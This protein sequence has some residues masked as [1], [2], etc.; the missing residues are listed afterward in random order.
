MTDRT[1]PLTDLHEVRAL[2]AAE[3]DNV[4]FAYDRTA[5][6]SMF[7]R[8]LIGS[9]LATLADRDAQIAELRGAAPHTLPAPDG[10]EEYA[11]R[12]CGKR[13]MVVWLPG[14]AEMGNWEIANCF[15]KSN[16][17]RICALLNRKP[18]PASASSGDTMLLGSNIQPS[19]IKIGDREIQLGE[20][21][22]AAVKRGAFTEYAWNT[23]PD[24]ERERHI[25]S[26]I[27]WL[28]MI[29]AEPGGIMAG[30][31]N[32]PMGDVVKAEIE[33]Q[34][35]PASGDA[36]TDAKAH[37]GALGFVAS[38]GARHPITIAEL[39]TIL[40]SDRAATGRRVR[41]ECA[42][43]SIVLTPA[44]L[45]SGLDRV[46]WAEGLIKQ[47]PEKHEGRNSWLLNYGTKKDG[48]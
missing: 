35:S 4:R 27:K 37:L 13:W 45:T 48:G 41:E 28:R 2:G 39:A 6:G 20:A 42:K 17:E 21:V 47:L 38:A 11:I 9:L 43:G 5:P 12:E 3:V 33:R 15:W 22:R 14:D 32:G 23:L 10:V 7:G 16:A 34:R 25:E 1:Q 19:H 46:R 8:S 31:P 29:E 26:A 40:T 30:N 24:N 18:S 44:E 36:T